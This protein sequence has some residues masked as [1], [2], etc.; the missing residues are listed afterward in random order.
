[1]F[2]I[3]NFSQ[4][5]MNLTIFDIAYVAILLKLVVHFP[6]SLALFSLDSNASRRLYPYSLAHILILGNGMKP[7]GKTNHPHFGKGAMTIFAKFDSPPMVNV[8]IGLT[9]IAEIALNKN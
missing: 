2:S 7:F 9:K 8:F 4:L 1:M 5:N 3:G 6:K